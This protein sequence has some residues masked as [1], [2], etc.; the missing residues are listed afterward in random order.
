M[1]NPAAMREGVAP[2]PT[3]QMTPQ[4]NQQLAGAAVEQGGDFLPVQGAP[5]GAGHHMAGPNP[6]EAPEQQATPEEQNAYNDLFARAIAA[7]NDSRAPPNG[8]SMA[9]EV[10]RQLATKGKEAYV[11]LGETAALVLSQLVETAKRQGV[12]YPGWILEE[13]GVDLIL[14]LS[15]IARD[16]GVIANL[17]EEDTPEFEKLMELSALQAAKWYGEHLLR[18]GQADQQGARAIL[19]E[20][21][22][23][24]FDSGE[25]DDWAMEEMDPQMR[26]ALADQAGGFVNGP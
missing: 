11:S 14:E 15:R 17:P 21:M 25:L 12:E 13:V 24:E 26:S 16:T 8:K 4:Q 7:V 10:K 2:P 23:R 3:Q 6:L 9:A 1:V 5:Q 19:D 18:T 20:Q 22:Q